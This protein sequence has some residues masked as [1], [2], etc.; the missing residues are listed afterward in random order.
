MAESSVLYLRMQAP[1]K[2]AG[3]MPT[4]ASTV[5]DAQGLSLVSNWIRAIQVCP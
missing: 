1:D 2:A 4:L 5:L 3:R